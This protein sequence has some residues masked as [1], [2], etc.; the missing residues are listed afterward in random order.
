MNSLMNLIYFSI[1]A[2]IG[3]VETPAFESFRIL[4]RFFHYFAQISFLIILILCAKGY[5][6]TVVP[7]T[8]NDLIEMTFIII[9]YFH[10]QLVLLIVVGVVS[11]N[12]RSNSNF[13]FVFR[14]DFRRRKIKFLF[15]K[16]SSLSAN[17]FN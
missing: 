7:F 4:T 11:R 3:S 9:L 13:L 17:L 14:L 16:K 15:T 1:Y 2:S 12:F 10:I 5:L 6:I 8:K